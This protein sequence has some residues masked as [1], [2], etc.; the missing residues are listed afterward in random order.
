M[1]RRKFL[2]MLA[3]IP[4]VGPSIAKLVEP[5]EASERWIVPQSVAPSSSLYAV[6]LTHK[7][8]SIWDGNSFVGEVESPYTERELADVQWA[9]YAGLILVHKNHEPMRLWSDYYAAKYANR[10]PRFSLEPLGFSVA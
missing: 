9:F 8:L 3:A 6:R 2:G 10:S 5:A 4:F 7:R 1:L